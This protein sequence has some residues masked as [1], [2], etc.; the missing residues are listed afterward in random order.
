M[1]WRKQ[2]KVQIFFLLQE[3]KENYKNDKDGEERVE[4]MSYSMRLMG[5]SWTKLVDNLM[6]GIRKIKCKHCGCLVFEYE[7]DKD[8]W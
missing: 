8:T 4:T 6:K 5:T 2:R 3:K 7:T 1:S